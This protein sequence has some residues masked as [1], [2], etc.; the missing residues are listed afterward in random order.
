KHPS[1]LSPNLVSSRR[2]IDLSRDD[3]Q[4]RPER[5]LGFFCS[6]RPLGGW[7]LASLSCMHFVLELL[8]QQPQDELKDYARCHARERGS[9]SNG[10]KTNELGSRPQFHRVFHSRNPSPRA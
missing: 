3:V 8:Y 2:A 6:G 4:E 10:E 1:S 5:A 9:D 7:S